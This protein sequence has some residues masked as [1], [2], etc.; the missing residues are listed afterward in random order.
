[1]KHLRL[2]FLLLAVFCLSSQAQ[3]ITQKLNA[4]TFEAPNALYMVKKDYAN[5]RKS[6]NPKAAKASLPPTSALGRE[7]SRLYGGEIVNDIGNNPNWITFDE[8]GKK[9]YV[10]KTVMRKIQGGTILPSVYNKPYLWSESE[11]EDYC[12]NQL[13]WRIGKLPHFKNLYIAETWGSS[14]YAHLHLGAMVNGVLVFKYCV[15]IDNINQGGRE[16]LRP[17]TY[18]ISST[19]EDGER[20]YSFQLGSDLFYY[21]KDIEGN[22]YQW[23]NLCKLPDTFVYMLFKDVIDKGQT[24][25]FYLTPDSFSKFPVGA[26]G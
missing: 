22:T 21:Y 9:Y 13:Q 17:G 7:N 26:L 1:M 15:A 18:K 24:G 11:G 3:N 2:I 20:V 12:I 6:P 4:L 19:V 16:P 8:M 10:S 14:P 25:Y 23:L 5:I